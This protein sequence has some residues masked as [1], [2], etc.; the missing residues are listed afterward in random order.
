MLVTHAPKSLEDDLLHTQPPPNFE[1]PDFPPAPET[2][3]PIS[4]PNAPRLS[5]SSADSGS[6]QSILLQR[7]G[8]PLLHLRHRYL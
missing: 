7:A 2:E 5:T 4:I 8:F 1:L 6:G 3:I